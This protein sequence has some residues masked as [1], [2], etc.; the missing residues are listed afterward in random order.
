IGPMR[1]VALD[2]VE[3]PLAFPL[4][5]LL[6]PADRRLDRI[7]RLEPHQS[8]DTIACGEA[9]HGLAFVLEH[10]L[11]EGSGHSH[12]QRPVGLA[13]HEVDVEHRRSLAILVIP[14]KAGIHGKPVSR[15][16]PGR[17]FL[18]LVDVATPRIQWKVRPPSTASAA[19]VTKDDSVV[20][21]NKMA[22]AISSG[23]AMRF[24]AY[25]STS[26]SRPAIIGVSTMPGQTLL[27]RMDGANSAA[28]AR[29]RLTTPPFE[30]A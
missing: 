3:F 30:A 8:V 25:R 2:Q 5:D 17:R 15:P 21:R 18:G 7:V 16:S 6:L 4:L 11:R 22:C 12:L 1:V 13:C 9:G 19:P 14:A 29:V 24:S 10:P 23:S 27:T 20:V 26:R 28:R